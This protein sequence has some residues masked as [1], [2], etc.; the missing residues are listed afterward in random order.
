MSSNTRCRNTKIITPPIQNKLTIEP[1]S[2]PSEIVGGIKNALARGETLERAQ[3]S[4]INAG[5]KKEEVEEAMRQIS[6]PEKIEQLEIPKQ[7]LPQDISVTKKTKTKTKSTEKKISTTLK[8][9]L[10]ISITLILIAATLLGL[11]WDKLIN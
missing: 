2:T 9:V 1:L 4:F 10:I 11:F 3:Q 5:Y 7:K 8:V 6:K